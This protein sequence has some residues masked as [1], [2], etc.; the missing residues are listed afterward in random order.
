MTEVIVCKLW[1]E[2]IHYAQFRG[3]LWLEEADMLWLFVANLTVA[4]TRDTDW[5]KVSS[6][7]VKPV[8]LLCVQ[9]ANVVCRHL[10]SQVK[11]LELQSKLH[12]TTCSF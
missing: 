1:W 10:S 6:Q 9:V 8:S 3:L 5:K 11:H 7:E 2:Q 4:S 12:E